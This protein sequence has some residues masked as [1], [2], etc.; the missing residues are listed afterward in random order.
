MARKKS[1]TGRFVGGEG[2]RVTPPP[3]KKPKKKK[4]KKGG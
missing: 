2:T 1:N 4:P 3:E